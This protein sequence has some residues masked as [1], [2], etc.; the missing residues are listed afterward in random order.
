MLT[1]AQINPKALESGRILFFFSG[2]KRLVFTCV[3]P[4]YMF[5]RS[6]ISTP[7]LSKGADSVGGQMRGDKECP[8]SV[9]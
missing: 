1:P 5:F 2:R 9:A 3:L 4:R 8:T 7:N 6:L